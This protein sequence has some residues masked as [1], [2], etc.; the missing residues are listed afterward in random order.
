MNLLNVIKACATITL[1]LCAASAPSQAATSG[2]FTYT[3]NGTFITITGYDNSIPGLVTIPAK[4]VNKP[5]TVIAGYAFAYRNLVTSVSIPSSVTFIG[6]Y[7]FFYCTVMTKVSGGAGVLTISDSAF[8]GCSSLTSFTI[9]SKVT[10]LGSGVLSRCTRLTSMTIPPGVTFIGDNAFD[11]CSKL[12]SAHF[13][14]NA[15]ALG[16]NVFGGA[17]AGFTIYYEKGK[18]G[19]TS[20]TWNGYPAFV[21][22]PEIDIQQPRG[23]SLVDGSSNKSFGTATIGM[24]GST[25]TF[26]IKNIGKATL[27]GFNITQNGMNPADFIVT[28]PTVTSIAPGDSATFSVN[29]KP[30]GLDTREAAMHI[31]SNDADESPFDIKLSGMGVNP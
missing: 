10:Y 5:V 14:G 13:L 20:P 4:I 19:F 3:D 6:D 28:A 24:T 17:V 7:A 18:S 11:S 1:I 21:A 25:K 2:A 8:G 29:F 16:A 9:P 27:S 23:S 31:K 15:P 30:T 12:A 22:T 26:T